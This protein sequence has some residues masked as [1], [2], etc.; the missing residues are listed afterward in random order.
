M[1]AQ[2]IDSGLHAK[3]KIRIKRV[4]QFYL[5]TPFHF[6]DSCEIVLIEES[7][8]KRVVGDHIDSFTNGDLVFLGPNLPHIWQNDSLFYRKRK[9]YRVKAMVIYFSAD[10]ILELAY[11]TEAFERI[12]ALFS[13]AR[14]GLHILGNTKTCLAKEISNIMQEDGLKQIASFL[15]IIDTLSQTN[16][17]EYLASEDYKNAY[18]VKD[19]ERF[20]D[21]YQF[22]INNFH[23][24][25]TLEEISGIA[26]MTPNAFSR[27]FKTRTNK[28]VIRF[29]NE[30]RIGHACKLL[31]NLDYSISDICYECGFNNMVNFNKFFKIITKTTPSEIRKN[32]KKTHV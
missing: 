3:K 23:R 27:Y 17:Y 15:N 28:S 32:I 1:K 11:N 18:T 7:F 9:G 2:L 5:D 22:L 24:E 13:N 6:H 25:I 29:I 19:T 10:I 8:G 4:D 20:N 30:L 26:K 31:K 14:R 12:E 21:V 16:E